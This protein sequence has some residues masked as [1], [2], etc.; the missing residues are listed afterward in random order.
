MVMHGQ[1]NLHLR[2]TGAI[3]LRFEDDCPGFDPLPKPLP[4]LS[5]RLT[6]PLLRIDRSAW[7]GQWDL[8]RVGHNLRHFALLS[9]DDLV[10]IIA[11]ADAQA[12]W[13]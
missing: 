4:M 6:F 8:I 13:N 9:L 5:P 3:A 12:S 7:L 10:Q 2:F 1:R 11:N